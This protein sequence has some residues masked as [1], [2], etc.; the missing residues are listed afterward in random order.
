MPEGNSLINLGGLSEP[1][2]VLIKKVSAAVGVIYEPF[3]VKRMARAEAEAEKIRSIARIELTEIEQ[4][5]IERFIYQETRKQANIEQITAQA[6]T[7]LPL[8]TKVETLEEDWVADFFGQCATVSDIEMQ[9]IWARVLSGEATKPGTFSKR[10]VAFISTIDKRD[11]ALF[12]TFC[13]F[14]WMMGDPIPLIYE[15][16]DDIYKKQGITFEVMK[17]LDAIGLISFD[18]IGGYVKADLK[19]HEHAFY[20]GQ[21]TIVE[22]GADSN[23]HIDVGHALLTSIGKELV[24]IC[25]S[26]SNSNFYDYVI[27]KWFEQG[28]V[29]SSEAHVNTVL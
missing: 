11:A 14:L 15:Y 27:R 29:L 25:G 1:A 22:F 8:D 4:R 2:T 16:T 6:I 5:A 28:L 20:Y 18:P 23:N 19:R 9:S 7:S 12:T 3:H 24:P 21:P 10:T 26:K 17:H 13:Q